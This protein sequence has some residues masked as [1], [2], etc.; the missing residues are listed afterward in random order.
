MYVNGSVMD[1]LTSIG[2]NVTGRDGIGMEHRLIERNAQFVEFARRFEA[3]LRDQT[4]IEMAT[5]SA[6]D[7]GALVRGFERL[8]L[9][10]AQ[11]ADMA[12]IYG[13]DQRGD[14]EPLTTPTAVLTGEYLRIGLG[15]EWLEPAF[16]GDNS[17]T[18]VTPNGVA[19]DLDG[20]ARS[21][22]MS[23]RP[24]LTALVQRLLAQDSETG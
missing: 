22:L 11:I 4:S 14:I 24:N 6:H 10:L 7:R 8:D 2:R 12:S 16:E 20:L 3:Y 9:A 18:V 23:A 15:A 17:L 1:A 5:P 13:A 21:A 19:L